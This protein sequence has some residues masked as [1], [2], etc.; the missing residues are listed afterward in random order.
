LFDLTSSVSDEFEDCNRM[1][2]DVVVVVD[3]Y[4]G[5]WRTSCLHLQDSGY[6]PFVSICQTT[7]LFISWESNLSYDFHVTFICCI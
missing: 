4:K 2:F 5:L 1:V 3:W 7:R 6:R